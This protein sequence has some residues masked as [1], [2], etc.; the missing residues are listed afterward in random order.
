M[1]DFARATFL[2]YPCGGMMTPEERFTKIENA[3]QHSAEIMAQLT[4]STTR[5]E[6]AIRDLIV[7]SRTLVDAQKLYEQRTASLEERTTNLKERIPSFEERILG[8]EE[9]LNAAFERTEDAR[10]RGQE[11][12]NANFNALLQ[13]QLETEQKLQRWIDR[14][15]HS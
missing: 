13:A 14:Q 2:Q 7:I 6:A 9:R 5:N 10:K 1:K 12:F 11:E 8:F 4:V 3:L 15:S